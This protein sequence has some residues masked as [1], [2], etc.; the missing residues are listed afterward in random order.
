MH[1]NFYEKKGFMTLLQYDS[2]TGNGYAVNQLHAMMTFLSYFRVKRW[3][4]MFSIHFGRPT[5]NRFDF[6]IK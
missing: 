6:K 1:T 2:P 5:V 3:F 4:R